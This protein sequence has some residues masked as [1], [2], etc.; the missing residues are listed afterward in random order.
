MALFSFFDGMFLPV[1]FQF[2]ERTPK[3]EF[4]LPL[5]PDGDSSGANGVLDLTDILAFMAY[6]CGDRINIDAALSY[7]KDV[8]S[9][10]KADISR[11][12]RGKD[13]GRLFNRAEGFK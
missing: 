11:H 8:L 10:D 2:D 12:A 1:V 7:F 13:L 3:E 4:V 5:G 6:D 9:P